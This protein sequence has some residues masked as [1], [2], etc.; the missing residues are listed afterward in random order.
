MEG[1][2]STRPYHIDGSY[3][4]LH[5][6]VVSIAD[7]SILDEASFRRMLSLEMKRA[8]RSQ[9]PFLLCLFEME[10]PLGS[11][12]TRETLR[13]I[14]PILDSNTRDTDVTGW[15]R[16]KGVLAVMFTEISIAEQSSI[17]AA[18]MS[19]MSAQLRGH[20]TTQQFG[21]L[22]ISFQILPQAESAKKTVPPA[23]AAP[24]YVEPER[25]DELAQVGR[26]Q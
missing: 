13:K 25:T 14:L 1:T 16:E 26:P 2:V 3:S 10:T 7:R 11:E 12:K 20:L 15:Y 4:G 17:V 6:S 23:S 9:K 18:I 19:R 24:L 22:L 5:Q 8:Q 21:Q